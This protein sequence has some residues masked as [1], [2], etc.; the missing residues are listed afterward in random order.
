MRSLLAPTFLCCA[1]CALSLPAAE[2]AIKDLSLAI[3]VTG[4]DFDY[5]LDGESGTASGGDAFDSAYALRLGSLWS[6][7]GTGR[8][9]GLVLGGELV[10]QQYT[11]PSDGDLLV[12]G[13]RAQAGYGIAFNDR[14]Q[15]LIAPYLGY[16]LASLDLPATP[17]YA[18]F[19]GDGTT[20][21]YGLRADIH[22]AFNEQFTLVCGLGYGLSTTDVS[23]DAVD[24]SLDHD[25]FSFGL[26]LTWRWDVTPP[27][28][29]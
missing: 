18:A 26:G 5:T 9:R 4:A 20:L 2:L 17:G 12:Y 23:T 11:F 3:D 10:L 7:A 21:E 24:I 28:L 14:L 15:L 6:L 1:S 25:G 13:L 19:S 27:L 8:N 16:G 29:D 22:Y